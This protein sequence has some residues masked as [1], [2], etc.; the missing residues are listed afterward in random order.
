M[1]IDK[2]ARTEA[3]GLSAKPNALK[4]GLGK[5]IPLSELKVLLE[6]A[7][8]KTLN[9]RKAGLQLRNI[10]NFA[11]PRVRKRRAHILL[12]PAA[13]GRHRSQFGHRFCT[14]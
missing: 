10:K 4:A 9:V 3:A 8:E 12:L 2:I 1:V 13:Y 7:P 14:K 11:E 6:T 5:S